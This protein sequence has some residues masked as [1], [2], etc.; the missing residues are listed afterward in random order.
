MSALRKRELVFVTDAY[1][2]QLCRHD[3]RAGLL[4]CCLVTRNYCRSLKI[5]LPTLPKWD[6]YRWFGGGAEV[7]SAQF[8]AA[9]GISAAMDPFHNTLP[10]AEPTITG[11][12]WHCP[13]CL[14]L[15]ISQAWAALPRPQNFVIERQRRPLFGHPSA[16]GSRLK[17]SPTPPL[18]TST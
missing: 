7:A 10:W 4:S 13:R 1:L 11:L 2:L 17:A 5:E 15:A 3:A 6:R 18:D 8:K 16:N 9:A 12:Q 14:S